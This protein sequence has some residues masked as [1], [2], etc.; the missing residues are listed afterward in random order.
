MR[1]DR[2][3]VLR[4][5]LVGGAITG[6]YVVAYTALSALGLSAALANSIAFGS[7]IGLQYVGQTI[8]T[9]RRDLMDAAQA[10]RFG[11]MVGLGYLMSAIITGLIA[12]AFGWPAAIAAI[13]VA[14]VLPI[15]N[16]IF[17]KLWVFTQQPY[18]QEKQHD[19]CL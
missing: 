10:V 1:T 8:F 15:Q 18:E 6:F 3:E 11:I 13:F 16:F 9:F 5:V 2:A 17:M 7:A 12:P 14:I 19:A 4:F